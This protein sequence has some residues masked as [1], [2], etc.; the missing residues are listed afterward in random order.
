MTER[1]LT[2]RT[3]PDREASSAMEPTRDP[4]VTLPDLLDV[5]LDKGVYLDLDLIVTVADIPLIGVSLRAMVAGMETMLERG[6]MLDWDEQ[7]REWARRSLSRRV[8]LADDEDVVARMAGGHR[9]EEPYVT[10]R[11][12]IVYLT[13]R[14]VMV[15]RADPRELLWQAPLDQITEVALESERS[16][17]GDERTR[18]AVTTP[19]GRTLLSAAT[20][21]RLGAQL[22]EAVLGGPAAVP[23]SRAEALLQA[24]VWYLEDL[25]GG[26]VWRGGTG[27]LH[28]TDGLTWKGVRDARPAVR[29]RPEQVRSVDVVRGR[30]TP[31]GREMLVV[32]GDATTARLATED[33]ARWAEALSDVA[34]AGTLPGTGGGT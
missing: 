6:M 27:T 12:G 28:R 26:S 30:R 15:W 7:T 29:L 8:P 16:I 20:P 34:G 21:E 14:R 5:L 4:R 23:E 9:Q 3:G 10:W 31:V 24:R 13:T 19:A 25:A 18:V 2:T 11:P 22:R 33:T 17:G 32:R 1:V